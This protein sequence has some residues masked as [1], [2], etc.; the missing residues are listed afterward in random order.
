MV[1]DRHDAA[2]KVEGGGGEEEGEVFIHCQNILPNRT[3][4]SRA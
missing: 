4:L 2:M 3:L 1:G